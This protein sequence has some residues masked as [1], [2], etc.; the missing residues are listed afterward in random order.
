[1]KAVNFIID[2]VKKS[3][4]EI[5][6]IAIGTCV[7]L[8]TAVRM[9]PE[10]IPLIKKVIYMGGSFFKPG[11]TTRPPQNLTGGWTLRRQKYVCVLLSRNRLL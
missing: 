11:N 6:I 5:T 2:E 1:M 10:I 9:A 8:A 3:P 7:N 4:N